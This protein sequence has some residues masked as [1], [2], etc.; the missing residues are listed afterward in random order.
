M[1]LA[2][3]ITYTITDGDNDPATTSV[4]VPIGDTL[5]RYQEFAEAHAETIEGMVLGVI[6]PIARLSVPVDISAL[7]GNTAA[8]TSDVEQLASFQFS[9]ANQD[10][11]NIN[12]PARSELDVVI[13]SD[14]LDTTDVDVA[15]F[16]T[17]IED[18][19]GTIAPSGIAED[20][21]GSLVYARKQTKN[22]GRAR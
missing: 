19:N 2:P 17:L 6:Q 22:S 7:V 4:Y 16:I 8:A 13:G 20:A 18:G 21:I 10:P 15:A 5:A 9:D 11:V 1:P 3:I 14:A 12:I